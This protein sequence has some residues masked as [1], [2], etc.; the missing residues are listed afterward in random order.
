[1]VM[2]TK[3]VEIHVLILFEMFDHDFS[4]DVS[5]EACW[6]ENVAKNCIEVS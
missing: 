2:A 3:V 5:N 6:G 1:M 4:C